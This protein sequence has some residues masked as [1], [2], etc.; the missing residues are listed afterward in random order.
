MVELSKSKMNKIRNLAIQDV[1]PEGWV[2]RIG[3]SVFIPHRMP[4]SV[5]NRDPVTGLVYYEIR[6]VIT[7]R[8]GVYVVCSPGIC[9]RFADG[10]LSRSDYPPQK[11]QSRE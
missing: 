10:K 6:D 9:G 4:E 5:E 7:L 8:S 11:K 1:R 3:E 2:P